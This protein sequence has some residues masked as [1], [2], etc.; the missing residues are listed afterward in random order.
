MTSTAGRRVAK[1][2]GALQPREAVLAWLAEAQRAPG[3]VAHVQSFLD[4][5]VEAAPL[6]VIGARVVAAVRAAL[7]GQPR[8]RVET[9][10]LRAQGDAVFLFCLV[11]GL[12]RQALEVAQLEGLRASATFFWLG[13]LLGGPSTDETAP[14]ARDQDGT[15][16]QWR[17]VVAGL[18]ARVRVDTAARTELERRYLTGHDVLLADAAAD[19]AE[20]AEIVERLAG[21]ADAIAPAR[22]TGTRRAGRPDTAASVAARVA[23]QV[24]W[25]ADVARVRAYEILGD[26]GRA[27]SI[28]ERHL[29]ADG[30]DDAPAPP[31]ALD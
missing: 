4:L 17:A 23:D 7:K 5:P 3:L 16:A 27:V 1:L 11:V 30:R 28:M 31:D 22:G 26:R 10:A 2:E 15:W 24:A 18:Q 13:A 9:A 14:S 25:L 21:V 19:W 8:D 6:S 29:R 20:F 12:N